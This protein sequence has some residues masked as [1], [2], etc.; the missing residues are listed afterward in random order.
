MYKT[1]LIQILRS[2]SRAELW[3]LYA[4]WHRINGD[5]TMCCEALLKQVRSYQ[6]SPSTFTMP[7][8]LLLSI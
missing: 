4:R 1:C 2:E 7:Y 8:I 6:V 5:L 3:G